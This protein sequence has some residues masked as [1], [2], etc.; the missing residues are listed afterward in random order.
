MLSLFQDR[1]F[2][3]VMTASHLQLSTNSVRSALWRRIQYARKEEAEY[4]TS[5]LLRGSPTVCSLLNSRN[6]VE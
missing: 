6:A 4:A 1:G 3:A 5:W 2:D